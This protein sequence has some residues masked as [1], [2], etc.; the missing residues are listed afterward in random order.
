EAGNGKEL[1]E[2]MSES[3]APDI[4]LLDIN[5]PVMNGF[6]TMAALNR[7][8]GNPKVIALTAFNDEVSVFRLYK[9]G[10]YAYIL[11]TFEPHE[12]FVALDAVA[13]NGTYFPELVQNKLTNAS[14]NE[15]S[16]TVGSLNERELLF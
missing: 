8:I 11:K 7:I 1:L 6:E 13:A 14:K 3:R 9:S 2:K 16:K 4:I 12:F 10:I 15:I 5:M